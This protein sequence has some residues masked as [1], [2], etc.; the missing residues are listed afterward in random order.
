MGGANRLISAGAA[1][2]A[3]LWRE[4]AGANVGRGFKDDFLGFVELLGVARGDQGLVILQVVE[5]QA[6][7]IPFEN[8]FCGQGVEA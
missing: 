3:G 2:E 7:G 5:N 4:F 1:D 8:L 6:D